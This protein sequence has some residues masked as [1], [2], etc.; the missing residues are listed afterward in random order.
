MSYSE[1]TRSIEV[2]VEPSY[3]EEQSSPENRHFVWAYRVRIE[4]HGT[5]QVQLLNRY[6]RITDAKGV[7]QEVEGPGVVGEQPILQPGA[8][9][10]YTSGCPLTT[11]SGIMQGRYEMQTDEGERFWINIPAFS[12]DSPHQNVRLN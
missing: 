8:S 11:P 10:V 5:E 3:L 4:N 2:T 9:F 12:L 7:T 6:W 1:T